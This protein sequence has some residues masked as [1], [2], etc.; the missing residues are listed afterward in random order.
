[1][2]AGSPGAKAGIKTGDIITMVE[3]TT[4]DALH[5]LQDVLVQYTPGRTVTLQIYRAGT[6][7]TLDDHAG[8]ASGHDELV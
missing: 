4:I 2:I 5:P 3:G 8:H 6:Y 1:V 7:L